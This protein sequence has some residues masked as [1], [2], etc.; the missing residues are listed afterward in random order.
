MVVDIPLPLTEMVPGRARE[1]Q[2]G[3]EVHTRF[4]PD[5]HLP[6]IATAAAGRTCISMATEIGTATATVTVTEHLETDHL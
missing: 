4:H 2:P 6:W 1:C 3:H 5:R